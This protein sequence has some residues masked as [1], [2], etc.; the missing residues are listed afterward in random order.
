[1]V[2]KNFNLRVPAG[3]VV[4]IVGA[5][6]GGKSTLAQLLERLDYHST[7]LSHIDKLFLVVT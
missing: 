1:M 4:A 5:S 2:L 6:G 7:I 3:R